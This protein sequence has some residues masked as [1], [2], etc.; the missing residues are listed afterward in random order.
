MDAIWEDGE[1]TNKKKAKK[2]KIPRQPV[3][4]G[5]R[6]PWKDPDKYP[7]DIH[8]FHNN[9]WDALPPTTPLILSTR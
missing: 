8:F 5:P 4:E 7:K 3:T 6:K 1:Q 9:L 2:P